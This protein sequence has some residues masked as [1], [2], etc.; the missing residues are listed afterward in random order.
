VEFKNV[1]LVMVMAGRAT[2]LQKGAN[3]FY[4]AQRMPL[5]PHRLVSVKSR[6]VYLSGVGLLKLSWKKG[7]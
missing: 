5:P 4:M 1:L 7:R 6:M 2:C 3:A